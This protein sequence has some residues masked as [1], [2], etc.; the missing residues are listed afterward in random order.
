MSQ[1]AIRAT[2]LP[3]SQLT[4]SPDGESLPLRQIGAVVKSNSRSKEKFLQRHTLRSNWFRVVATV[5]SFLG[6]NKVFFDTLAAVLLAT[7]AVILGYSQLIVT[8]E[9]TD[10]QKLAQSPS[11]A[12]AE[13]YVRNE[14]S[15][16]YENTWLNI[17]NIGAVARDIVATTA[18]FVDVS[19]TLSDAEVV[20]YTLPLQGYYSSSWPLGN[21]QGNVIRFEGYNN[22]LSYGLLID[23]FYASLARDTSISFGTIGLRKYVRVRWQS[24]SGSSSEQFLALSGGIGGRLMETTLGDSVFAAYDLSDLSLISWTLS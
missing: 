16:Y 24:V 7:M 21:L 13:T 14:E 8:M 20:T 18:T 15:G 2:L 10:L 23:A 3:D 11:F 1:Q 12:V 4:E 9:Q 19:L 22:N 5:R 17:Y 6:R